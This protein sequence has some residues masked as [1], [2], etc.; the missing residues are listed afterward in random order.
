MQLALTI[1]YYSG[2]WHDFTCDIVAP[3]MIEHAAAI[4]QLSG[5]DTDFSEVQDMVSGGCCHNPDTSDVDR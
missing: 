5:K 4:C 1:T 2:F 3:F